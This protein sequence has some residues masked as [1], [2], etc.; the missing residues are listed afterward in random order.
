[1]AIL[2]QKLGQGERLGD[3]FAAAHFL[4]FETNLVAAGERGGQLESI[5]DHIAQ[6]WQRELE[7][8]QAS[9]PRLSIPSSS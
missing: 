2:S 8:R 9:S 6:F 3:A 7:F 4:P 1:M 5:F